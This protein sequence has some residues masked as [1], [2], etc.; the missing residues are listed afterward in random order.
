M[1][2]TGAARPLPKTLD[3][4]VIGGGIIGVST[5]YALA[6]AGVRVGVV[7]KGPAGGGQ[8]S[9]DSGCGRTPG[10]DPAEV[11]PAVRAKQLWADIQVQVDVGFRNAGVRYLQEADADSQQH[12]GWLQRVRDYGVDA[13]LLERA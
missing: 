12:Q 2:N 9:R 3:V 5:A 11:P 13:T 6:R 4:A 10:R 1:S 7:E 8:S